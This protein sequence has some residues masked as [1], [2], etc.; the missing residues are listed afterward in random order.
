[1]KAFSSVSRTIPNQVKYRDPVGCGLAARVKPVYRLVMFGAGPCRDLVTR[2]S[3][4]PIDFTLKSPF[5]RR[6][7][8]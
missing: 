1:M 7:L 4:S 8:T 6:E 5:S 2:G 3:S